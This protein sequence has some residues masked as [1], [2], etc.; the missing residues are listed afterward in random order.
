M[1]W[2]HKML[3]GFAAGILASVVVYLLFKPEPAP[4]VTDHVRIEQLV[5][6]LETR[7]QRIDSLH[8]VVQ[9]LVKDYKDLQVAQDN[10]IHHYE[11]QLD[12][13]T[14]LPDDES[15]RYFLRRTRPDSD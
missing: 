14:A 8:A 9:E 11:N 3:I 4:V 12:S 7:E 6:E 1:K 15:V 13:I 10:I 2:Y 5:K